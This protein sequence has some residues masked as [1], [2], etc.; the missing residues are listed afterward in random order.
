MNTIY[1]YLCNHYTVLVQTITINIMDIIDGVN[2]V[3]FHHT[4]PYLEL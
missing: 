1:V 4:I 3:P 2:L